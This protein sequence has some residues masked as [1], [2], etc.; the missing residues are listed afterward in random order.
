MPEITE[1]QPV[2]PGVYIKTRVLP[3]SL[4]VKEAA[5]LLGVGR[6]A[7]SNLLNGNAA[8]SPEM[9][10]R[11]EKAFGV[12]QHELLQMQALFDQYQM[13]Q[14]DQNI[15]VRAYVPSFLKITAREIERW[16][17]SNSDPRSRLPVLLRKLIHSTGQGLSHVDFPGYD[18]TE[19]KGWDGR[20]NADAATPWIPVGK[21]GWEFGCNEDPKRKA[22]HDYAARV[23]AIPASD[24]AEIIFIL[25][26]PRK[27]NAKD[28][29]QKEKQALGDWKSVK[30]YDSSILN[31][32]SNNR[33][34]HK[35]G[36]RSKWDRLMRALIHWMSS[37]NDGLPPQ[38][39]N[40]RNSSLRLQSKI[41]KTLSSYGSR[42]RPPRL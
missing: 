9:A 25:V 33:S 40:S 34:R 13:R 15:A 39:L 38:I 10:S 36:W 6:P 27:W 2:H 3:N 29:W 26:T 19:R 31:S 7:L 16:V 8:L 41:I 22:E 24:R 20:V 37:G 11:V 5:K 4:S 1:K 30:A 12:S 18:N 32:G 17:D 23:N 14:R 28:K 42:E 35:G 21:S